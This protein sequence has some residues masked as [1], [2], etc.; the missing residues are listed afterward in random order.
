MERWNDDTPA[1]RLCSISS[2][3]K[4]DV[5]FKDKR[6]VRAHH[7][8][9]AFCPHCNQPGHELFQCD[10]F[11]ALPCA[12]RRAFVA[13][14]KICYNCMR[15]NHTVRNCTSKSTCRFCNKSHHTWLH[16]E[17]TPAVASVPAA[18]TN[19]VS[20]ADI[21][22]A[23]EEIATVTTHHCT[24]LKR[25]LLPTALVHVADRDG[26]QQVC[27]IL[28]DGGSE[29][30]LISESCAQRL[31]LP[32][33][34]KRVA[35][36]GAGET[37]VGYTRGLVVIKV[38]SMCHPEESLQAEALVLSKMTSKL[39]TE[40]LVQSINWKHLR[41][42]RLADPQFD[43]P[44]EIDII[45]GA[46]FAMEINCPN[47][48]KGGDGA[49]VAQETI[50]GWVVGG[51]MSSI[52][53][54]VKSFHMMFDVDKIFKD[55]WADDLTKKPL[56]ENEEQ[57]CEE[58]FAETVKRDASGRYEVRLPLKRSPDLLGD[59][60]QAALARLSAMERKFMKDPQFRQLYV[61]FMRDY[62]AK[63]HMERVPPEDVQSSKPSYV[64][65]H[66]A[67]MRPSSTTTKLRVVFD[68]SCAIRPRNIALN[69]IL[70]VGPKI[71][72]DFDD[73]S[74]EIPH[75][76]GGIYFRR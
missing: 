1:S 35:V 73:S 45:L 4:P 2:V 72:P 55:Y 54:S 21:D 41:N 5:V 57:F 33:K 53:S 14:N 58:Y 27:R 59:S 11:K 61:D 24:T 13:G 42:L 32:R 69:G 20:Q 62:E 8:E 49:P 10:R 51:K 74:P 9:M 50:F 75:I 16:P 66:M 23:A 67:V 68:A 34:N 22:S 12:D 7:T 26:N 25:A 18:L 19:T 44:A 6:V 64:I 70:A 31:R 56:I 3:K 76:P 46:E 39:P 36:N 71:Q 38:T 52:A 29:C 63:G 60:K 40:Q 15:P 28:I 43:K 17:D 47:I 65:P 30:S 37:V 48:I